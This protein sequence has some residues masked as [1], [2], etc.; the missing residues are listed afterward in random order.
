MPKQ[1]PVSALRYAGFSLLVCASLF[2]RTKSPPIRPTVTEQHSGTS[3][4]LQAISAVSSKI[5]W[6]SGVGGT[7]AVTTDGGATWHAHVVAG[8]EDLEFRDV[9]GFSDRVA[10]LLSSGQGSD[11]RIYKT[12]DG[13][14][15]WVLQFQNHDPKRFFDCFAFWNPEMGIAMS[16]SSGGVL[17]ILRMNDANTWTEMSSSPVA[18]PNE[19]GFAASGT[20]VQTGKGQRAWIGTGAAVVAR[21]LTTTDGGLNWT[22]AEAPIFHGSASSGVITLDFDDNSH[23]MIAGGDIADSTGFHDTVAKSGDGGK[24][25]H[26]VTRP[27]FRGA[28]YGINYLHG[29]VASQRRTVVITGPGGSAWSPDEGNTWVQLTGLA[30]YWAVGFA[31]PKSGWMVGT[32]GR[33]VKLTF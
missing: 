26:L 19:G 5:A 2:A 10:Y 23:G 16:D 6:S 24:T 29:N 8:A 13:G 32:N 18:L 9:Q 15:S 25:W 22:A 20:C 12:R 21:V 4:R 30:N 17:P 7:F 28:V 11:S 14:T 31:N 3:N 1:F 33:I 27:P